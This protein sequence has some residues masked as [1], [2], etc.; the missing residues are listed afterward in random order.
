MP[1]ADTLSND[2]VVELPA[3][4]KRPL[5]DKITG[6]AKEA[7]GSLTGDHSKKTEGRSK[8]PLQDSELTQ[9]RFFT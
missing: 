6:K 1:H 9:G 4:L 2:H 7:G 5:Q 3:D 8:L